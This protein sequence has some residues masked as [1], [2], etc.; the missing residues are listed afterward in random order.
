M[1]RVISHRWVNERLYF[2]VLWG[3]QAISTEPLQAAAAQYPGLVEDY[4][5]NR[6]R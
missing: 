2:R 4:L 5:T 1:L 3:N 6:L